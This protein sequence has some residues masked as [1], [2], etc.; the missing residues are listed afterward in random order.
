MAEAIQI[1][2]A[3]AM[4]DG[5]TVLLDL[6][7]ADGQLFTFRLQHADVTLESVRNAL[8]CV[9]QRRKTGV[10]N[11]VGLTDGIPGVAKLPQ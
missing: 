10:G 2:S 9:R 7:A 8:D 5:D 1:R 3:V 11:T 4:A 6:T